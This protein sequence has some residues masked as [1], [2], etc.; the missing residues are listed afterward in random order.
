M[1]FS[2]YTPKNPTQKLE[3]NKPQKRVKEPSKAHTQSHKPHQPI[4]WLQGSVSDGWRT[5]NISE[6]RGQTTF[7]VFIA[8]H[9]L[10]HD[11]FAPSFPQSLSDTHEAAITLLLFIVQA[12]ENSSSVQ[13]QHQTHKRMTTNKKFSSNASTNCFWSWK[14][15]KSKTHHVQLWRASK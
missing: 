4:S 5:E 1:I 12:N 15:W 7:Q 13:N 10:S 14:V 3:V 2:I 11:F 6:G 8:S 9:Y